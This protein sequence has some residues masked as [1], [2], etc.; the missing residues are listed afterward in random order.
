[1]G[2]ERED[3][4]GGEGLTRR[5]GSTAVAWERRLEPPLDVWVR[6]QAKGHRREAARQRRA[7]P[8]V[9]ARAGDGAHSGAV[10]LSSGRLGP[11]GRHGCCSGCDAKKEGERERTRRGVRRPDRGGVLWLTGPT[12]LSLPAA[13]F[14]LSADS[15]GREKREKASEWRLGLGQAGRWLVLFHQNRRAAIRC[16]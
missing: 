7:H 1:M 6:A 8:P 9:G 16:E 10:T 14:H 5:R 13:A 12:A 11:T 2:K 4:R 3:G 15:I